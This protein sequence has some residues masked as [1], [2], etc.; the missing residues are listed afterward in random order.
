MIEQD[1]TESLRE[2]IASA[3]AGK[4]PV[5]IRGGNSKRFYGTLVRAR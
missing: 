2:R 5:S 1:L 4:T 3:C